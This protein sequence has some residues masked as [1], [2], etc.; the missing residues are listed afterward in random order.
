MLRLI[1][2]PLHRVALRIAN[3]V[4]NFWY[5]ATGKTGE[6]VSVIGRDFDGQILLI[7]HSYGPEGWYF[8]GG[9]KGRNESPEAAARRELREETA[10]HIEGLKLVGV[11]D[12]ELASA[13]HRAHIFE[14]VIDDTPRADGRE[15]IEA[16]FFPT[17]SLPEP[18]GPQ[19]RT[20]LKL[21]QA[22][23]S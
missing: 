7:R 12:E 20:R 9:G 16:R 10:C 8:P 17:H 19:T 4:R 15:V 3:Q 21:W 11:L 1:P 23:R 22:R 6:G 13:P 5:R 18:L 14:G 2:K